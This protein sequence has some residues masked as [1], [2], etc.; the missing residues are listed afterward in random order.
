M[1]RATGNRNGDAAFDDIAV[2]RDR[3]AMEEI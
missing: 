2:A 3:W 1:A